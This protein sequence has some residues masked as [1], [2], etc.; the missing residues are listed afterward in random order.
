VKVSAVSTGLEDRKAQK[1]NEKNKKVDAKNAALEEIRKKETEAK[2]KDN[3]EEK[4][5]GTKDSSMHQSFIN[6]AKKHAGKIGQVD[7]RDHGDHN[8][9]HNGHHHTAGNKGISMSNVKGGVGNF[10]APGYVGM[11]N[12]QKGGNSHGGGSR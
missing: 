4:P 8:N 1:K 5:Q 2:H 3:S 9:K 10:Q 12:H 7:L 11:V 6:K